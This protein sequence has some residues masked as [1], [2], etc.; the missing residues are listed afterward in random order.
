MPLYFFKRRGDAMLAGKC[1]HLNGYRI[2]GAVEQVAGGNANGNVRGHSALLANHEVR[3]AKSVTGAELAL[4]VA[5]DTEKACP[6][7]AGYQVSGS[8]SPQKF[9]TP[10]RS[11]P[12]RL[13]KSTRRLG[14]RPREDIFDLSVGCDLIYIVVML[15]IS[16]VRHER[17]THVMYEQLALD[18]ESERAEHHHTVYLGRGCADRTEAQCIGGKL[19]VKV[20]ADGKGVL[21]KELL[22]RRRY[23]DTDRHADE[24]DLV[25]E[26]RLGFLGDERLDQSAQILVRAYKIFTDKN[27]EWLSGALAARK[28]AAGYE[29]R[30]VRQDIYAQRRS[31]DIAGNY[32]LDNSRS[33]LCR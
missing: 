30:H 33:R 22:R 11:A 31:H 1:R 12:W 27:I 9:I 29:R 25:K 15:E 19:A 24:S 32:L 3:A 13:C 26:V 2:L 16:E 8:A 10:S 17:M 6:Q 28:D 20:G 14:E 5:S 4:C 18:K 21:V 7:A 23:G